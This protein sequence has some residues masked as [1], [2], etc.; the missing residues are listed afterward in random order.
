[1][2]WF[3]PLRP[4]QDSTT[5][6]VSPAQGRPEPLRAAPMPSEGPRSLEERHA[7]WAQQRGAGTTEPG[8]LGAAALLEPALNSCL[9]C[10]VRKTNFSLERISDV[11]TRVIVCFCFF[12]SPSRSVAVI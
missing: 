12:S 11:D 4:R 7:H 3:P 5:L 1:M 6:S 10:T 2:F 8:R 9:H